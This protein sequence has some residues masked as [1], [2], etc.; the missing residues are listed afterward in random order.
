MGRKA[1]ERGEGERV[2]ILHRVFDLMCEG[3]SVEEASGGVGVR[4]GTL[5]QWVLRAGP[6]V[7]RRYWEARRLWGSALADEALVVARESVNQTSTV[8]KIRIDTLLR[9]A[10][11]A[12]PQEYG[13][14]QVVEHQGS[15]KLEIVVREEAKPLRQVSA[16]A[17][18]AGA[19]SAMALAAGSVPAIQ[20]PVQGNVGEVEEEVVEA[21]VEVEG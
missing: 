6:E 4:A 15:Q 18:V 11:K 12:N 14:K 7:Q 1:K 21:V 19:V 9:L 17:Q 16:T 2:E 8:D 5:R 13:E 20:S 3:Q 10:G